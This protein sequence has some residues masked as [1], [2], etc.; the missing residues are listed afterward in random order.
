NLLAGK[1]GHDRRN[2]LGLGG[3]IA[4]DRAGRDAGPLGDRHDLDRRYALFGQRVTC[5]RQDRLPARSELAD[6]SLGL[7]VGH[8]G[9]ICTSESATMPQEAARRM[10]QWSSF[11][12]NGSVPQ[13]YKSADASETRTSLRSLA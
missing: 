9:T 2:Q 6:Y 11:A 4:I 5:S 7:P 3:E 1:I 8:G 13:S 12:R 10:P